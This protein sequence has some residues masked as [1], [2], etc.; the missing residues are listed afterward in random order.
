MQNAFHIEVSW[1]SDCKKPYKFITT[2]QV[3]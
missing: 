3:K 2:K 1:R